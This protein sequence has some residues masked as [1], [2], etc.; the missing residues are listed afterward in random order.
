MYSLKVSEFLN[1]EEKTET[2]SRLTEKGSKCGKTAHV[3]VDHAYR[4]DL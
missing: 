4:P 1:C 3:R 2:I